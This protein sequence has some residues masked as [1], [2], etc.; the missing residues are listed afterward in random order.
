MVLVLSR[1]SPTGLGPHGTFLWQLLLL[2]LLIFLPFPRRLL[3]EDVLKESRSLF[4]IYLTN[5]LPSMSHGNFHVTAAG[6]MPSNLC[7]VTQMTPSLSLGRFL[8][9]GPIVFGTYPSFF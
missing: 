9:L 6:P 3:T 4:S 1:S 7:L 8:R 5:Y 2:E